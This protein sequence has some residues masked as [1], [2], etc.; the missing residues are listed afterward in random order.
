MQMNPF[1][2]F[3]ANAIWQHKGC[4]AKE[5]AEEVNVFSR[6]KQS[7][8]RFFITRNPQTCYNLRGWKNQGSLN[9]DVEVI[10]DGDGE[11]DEAMK[12]K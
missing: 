2:D 7:L 9:A 4:H 10:S 12:R 3:G 6:K 1:R 11:N 8:S 5:G